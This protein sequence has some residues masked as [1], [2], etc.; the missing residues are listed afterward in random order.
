MQPVNTRKKVLIAGA[1]FAGLCAAYWMSELGYEV[2]VVESATSIR[3]GGTAVNIRGNTIDI[4]R[5]MGLFDAIRANRMSLKRLEF[6]NQDDRTVR[7]LVVQ[8]DGAPPPDDDY[9]IPRDVLISLLAEAVRGRCDIAFGDRIAA[10]EEGDGMEVVFQSG[11]TAR[12]DMVLGCDGIHSGVRQLWFGAESSFIH[13][14]DQYFAI[15]IVDKLLIDRDTA[16]MFNVPRRGLML[17]AYRNKTDILFG[18]APEAP[19]T[20]DHRDV[21]QQRQLIAEQFAGMGWRADEL[22][23]ETAQADNFYFDRLCQVRMGAWSKGRVALV[24]D[25]GYCASPAAG[26]GGSLAIDGA[27]ALGD[28]LREAKGDLRMAFGL[29]EKNFRPTIAAVQAAAERFGLETLV[30]RTEAAIRARNESTDSTL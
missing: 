27:A 12:V 9:E 4:V 26:M 16:Q 24:G 17:N 15:A 2:S 18:F 13:S 25:A 7:T 20:Y 30:P 21:A 3:K 11:K 8:E 29:Y 10:L 14:L 5:R 1:S 22:L 6:K 28:A 19:I 23:R